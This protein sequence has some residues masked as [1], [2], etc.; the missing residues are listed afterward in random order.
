MCFGILGGAPARI[1]I[2]HLANQ[3]DSAEA[4]DQL[5]QRRRHFSGGD[6]A[7][8]KKRA[9]DCARGNHVFG[10][11]AYRDDGKTRERAA[12]VSLGVVPLLVFDGTTSPRT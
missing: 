2:L 9:R 6:D 12:D 4:A 1:L 3:A 11:T 8:S 10:G 7:P 5:R